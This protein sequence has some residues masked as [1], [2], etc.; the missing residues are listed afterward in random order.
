MKRP[1]AEGNRQQEKQN[2]KPYP[3]D[4]RL[5]VTGH[6]GQGPNCKG[7]LA[8]NQR[9]RTRNERP[10]ATS[11]RKSKTKNLTTEGTEL[12]ART[13]RRCGLDFQLPNYAITKF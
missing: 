11:N 12:R 13:Q 4:T 1:Q 9:E 5:Q 3:G 6:R 10:Q 2:Q 8:A 7:Y